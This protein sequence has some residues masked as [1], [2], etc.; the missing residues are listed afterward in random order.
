MHDS[1]FSRLTGTRVAIVLY[2]LSG[3]KSERMN[4][5]ASTGLLHDYYRQAA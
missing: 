1:P 2:L 4:N 3:G 5:S